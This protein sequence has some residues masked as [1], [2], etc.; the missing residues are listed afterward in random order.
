MKEQSVAAAVS[1]VNGVWTAAA[2]AYWSHAFGA[3]TRLNTGEN[4][5]LL[6]LGVLILLDSLVC[7]LGPLEAFYASAALS[8]VSI[9]GIASWGAPLASGG[10]LVSAILA[11]ATIGLTIQGARRKTVVPEEDHPLNLPVFG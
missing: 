7:F 6:V 1:L 5:I 3:S 10:F 9:V 11:A 2:G 8:F 4:P